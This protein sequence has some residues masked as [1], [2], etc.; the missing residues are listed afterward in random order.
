MKKFTSFFMTI[1]IMLIFTANCFA[2]LT[3][4]QARALGDN[5]GVEIGPVYISETNNLTPGS[6][7]AFFVQDESGG[8]QL[9]GPASI[10]NALI[11]DNNLVPG[12][13]VTVSGTNATY[14]GIYQ[15]TWVNVVIN[16][17][18]S[19]IP[20]AISIDIDKLTEI[21]PALESLE[22]KRIVITG[23]DING[24]GV[25][26][27]YSSYD[28]WKNGTNGEI[29]IQNDADHLVGSIIPFGNDI[30]ITGIFGRYDPSSGDGKYQIF[31]L[32]IVGGVTRDPYLWYEPYQELN[33]G[34]VYPDYDRTL[35]LTIKNGGE[36][37][38]LNISSF[39]AT[40]GDTA[41]FSPASIPDF[42][43]PPQTS[44]NINFVYTPGS[45]AGASHSAIYEFQS[46]DVSNQ[47]NTLTL[48]GAS[49]ATPPPTPAVW[50]NEIAYDDVDYPETEEF[51]EL[52]GIAGTTISNWTI[53]LYNG[54]NGSNYA[55]HVIASTLPGSD[56][57]FTFPDDQDGFGFY[58]LE[59]GNSS[60]PNADETAVFDSIQNGTDDAVRLT[61]DAGNQIH[62][63]AYECQTA[64][65]YE[66]LGFPNDLTPLADLSSD[67]ISL[68]LI[69]A[70]LEQP[71]FTWD[72]I[73][74]TPGE[75]NIDQSLP[76]PGLL[77]AGIALALLSFRRK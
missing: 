52:C 65:S 53:T 18:V 39:S 44:T 17:G 1:A 2:A 21:P 47:N 74:Y 7:H 23:V 4:A 61:D 34:V 42:S 67:T 72:V 9:A 68:S 60:V 35:Q 49:S 40:S 58:V 6:W 73:T 64:R 55:E 15:I 16:H 54:F 45:G 75:L 12:S 19:N 10:M 3:V 63:F 50:I 27:G 32:D 25:F 33:F 62:F 31:P 59:S 66:A 38:L 48:L 51:I 5:A 46:N 36:S 70:G 76:E 71:E 26:A 20:S 22:G 69:G 13:C 14:N 29:R 28:I 30:T 11:S 8:I 77:I 43:I 41:N 24:S 57:T 56:F 37:T